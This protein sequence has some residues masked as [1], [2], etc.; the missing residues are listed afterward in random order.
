MQTYR[1]T[2]RGLAWHLQVH[3]RPWGV[4]SCNN[5]DLFFLSGKSACIRDT[6]TSWCVGKKNQ[7][8]EQWKRKVLELCVLLYWFLF[9][10]FADLAQFLS[11]VHCHTQTAE[12]ASCGNSRGWSS[13]VTSAG[14]LKHPYTG[15]PSY[16]FPL[17]SREIVLQTSHPPVLPQTSLILETKSLHSFSQNTIRSERK[18]M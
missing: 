13:E 2:E 6:V 1:K 3:T 10:V 4:T 11:Q 5:L 12:Y 15:S 8:H 9:G 16:F 7:Y 17:S 18:L 14:F